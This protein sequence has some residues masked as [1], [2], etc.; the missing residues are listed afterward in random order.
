MP[1][2]HLSI[3]LRQ[4][5]WCMRQ[6]HGACVTRQLHETAR[7]ELCACLLRW[8]CPRLPQA[9]R[10]SAVYMYSQCM[11]YE[12]ASYSCCFC[13][14]IDSVARPDLLLTS[15]GLWV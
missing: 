10:S 1:P 11:S 9:G 8:V 5:I 14:L 13:S 3:C 12:D 7:L 15:E 2:E 6:C 4:F